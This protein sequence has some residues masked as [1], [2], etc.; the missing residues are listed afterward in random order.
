MCT[1]SSALERHGIDF[2]C[3]E[4]GM[5][6]VFTPEVDNVIRYLDDLIPRVDHYHDLR[7]AVK[8]D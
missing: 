4:V 8:K 2:P 7:D 5:H 6:G 1:R 3:L